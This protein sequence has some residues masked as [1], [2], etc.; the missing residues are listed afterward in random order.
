MFVGTPAVGVKVG[1]IDCG[2]NVAVINGGGVGVLVTIIGV[3]VAVM[4]G[5]GVGVFVTTMG[6]G[7]AVTT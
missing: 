3:G 1:E 2:V 7:V 5:G 6:V 4:N